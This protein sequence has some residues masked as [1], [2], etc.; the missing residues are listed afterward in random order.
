ML[1]TLM[2]LKKKDLIYTILQKEQNLPG[3]K[4][5]KLHISK[6]IQAKKGNERRIS[7]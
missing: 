3:V 7:S 4:N 5:G 6:N 1:V 2:I